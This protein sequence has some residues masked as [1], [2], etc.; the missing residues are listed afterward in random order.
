MKH[1]LTSLLLAAGIC[2]V[3]PADARTWTSADGASTFAGKFVEY[4]EAAAKVTITKGF[5]DITFGIDKLSEA[6]REW[7][8]EQQAKAKDAEAASASAKQFAAQKIGAKLREGVLSKLDDGK[9]A[10]YTMTTAPEY[11]VVYYSASW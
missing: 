8:K 5:R 1:R 4:D 2:A 9:F 3:S 7:L 6:D 10:D 11:Y